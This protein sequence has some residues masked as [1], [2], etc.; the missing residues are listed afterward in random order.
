MMD[1]LTSKDANI[2][3]AEPINWRLIV[4]SVLGVVVLIVGGFSYYFYQLNE[5]EELET[6][7]RAALLKA[8]TPE[9]MVKV[10]DQFPH[11]DQATLALLSAAQGSFSARDFAAA[12]ADYQR[13]VGAVDTDPELRDSAQV[14]LASSLEANGKMDDAINAYLDVARRGDKSP[15]APFAYLSAAMIYDERGDKGNER[16]IL[17]EAAGLSPD[18]QFVKEAQS[19]LK[20]LNATAQPAP[21]AAPAPAV[22]VKQP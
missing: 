3:D 4:Y 2:L 16:E 9:E 8:T 21:S 7:A 22:G 14:G 18:S 6:T 11:T 17:T 13:I 1:T 20:E 10:A 15:Y 5:R 19:K 12:I